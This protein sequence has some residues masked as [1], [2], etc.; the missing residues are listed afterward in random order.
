MGDNDKSVDLQKVNMDAVK[1]KEAWMNKNGPVLFV[2]GGVILIVV[3][4]GAMKMC[5]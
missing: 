2:V 4:G 5:G 3:M 1:K